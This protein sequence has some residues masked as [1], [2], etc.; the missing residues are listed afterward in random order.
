MWNNALR[1][2]QVARALKINYKWYASLMT[3]RSSWEKYNNGYWLQFYIFNDI[4]SLFEKNGR[5]ELISL[6][7]KAY[8][9]R[10]WSL[11]HEHVLN[12]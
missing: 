7:M 1:S 9:G 2:I 5:R 10:D 4:L 8:Y 11:L 12:N 3:A 6:L